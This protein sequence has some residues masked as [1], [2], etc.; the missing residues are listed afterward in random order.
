MFKATYNG[1][2]GEIIAEYERDGIEYVT[3]LFVNREQN[4]IDK[5]D[6]VLTSE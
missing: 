3:M 2:E 6:I 5:K 4:Y 1:E